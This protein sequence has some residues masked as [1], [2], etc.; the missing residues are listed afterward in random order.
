MELLTHKLLDNQHSL[1][2][3][4]RLET[5]PEEVKETEGGKSLYKWLRKRHRVI[6]RVCKILSKF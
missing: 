1:E 5:T 2:D 3:A 4:L 6:T